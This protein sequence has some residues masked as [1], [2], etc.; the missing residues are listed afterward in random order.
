MS[1]GATDPHD[2]ID[3]LCDTIAVLMLA[4]CENELLELPEDAADAANKRLLSLQ[5]ESQVD[6]IKAGVEVLVRSRVVH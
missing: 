5:G 2:D 1:A 3:K 4:L 6:V